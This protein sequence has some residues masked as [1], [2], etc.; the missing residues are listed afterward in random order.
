MLFL[1]IKIPS[2]PFFALLG[3]EI[4]CIGVGLCERIVLPTVV[5][6]GYLNRKR[7]FMHTDLNHSLSAP[8][9]R[10]RS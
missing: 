5:D 6:K 7:I 4:G 3:R 2:P 1:T 9:I 8:G 10:R